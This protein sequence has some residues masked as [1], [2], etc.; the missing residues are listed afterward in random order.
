MDG[1]ELA[2]R[3]RADPL[4]AGL[5]LI[6]LTGWKAN[7]EPPRPPGSVANGFDHHLMKP[8]DID[9]LTAVL[10][11]IRPRPEPDLA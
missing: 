4:H 6:A 5:V 3:L 2:M 10:A 7:D 9:D 8:P 1:H 11:A